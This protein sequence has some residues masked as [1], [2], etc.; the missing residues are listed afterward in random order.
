MNRLSVADDNIIQKILVIS[1]A[2]IKEE[3][4]D[5]LKEEIEDGQTGLVAYE[6]SDYGYLILIQDDIAENGVSGVPED[7]LRL[8]RFAHSV[9]V[10][11]IMLDCD[12]PE[13]C[14]V[15]VYEWR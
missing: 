8:Y 1:T 6:K 10:E 14:E 15:P 4:S 7:L 11:W 5:W 13:I 2:H 12:A 3:T 9:G